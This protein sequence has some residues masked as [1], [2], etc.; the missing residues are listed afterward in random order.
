[1]HLISTNNI[2]CH[3]DNNP[4]FHYIQSDDFRSLVPKLDP[5]AEPGFTQFTEHTDADH[6]NDFHRHPDQR[7]HDLRINA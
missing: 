3:S 4:H 1:M 2:H 7:T 6:G 5:A